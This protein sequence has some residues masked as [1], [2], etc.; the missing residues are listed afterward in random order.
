MLV[1]YITLDISL[2]EKLEKRGRTDRQTDRQ[3]DGQDLPIKSPR[4]KLK[5]KEVSLAHSVEILT[6]MKPFPQYE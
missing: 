4:R 6:K 1:Y 3:K 2:F 5:I